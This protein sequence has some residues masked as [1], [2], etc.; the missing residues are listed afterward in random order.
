MKINNPENPIF[1][2]SICLGTFWLENPKNWPRKA[3][4][5]TPSPQ[6]A[7]IPDKV[8]ALKTKI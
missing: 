7:Q 4:I 2:G 8:K 6:N 3:Y 1:K 5:P